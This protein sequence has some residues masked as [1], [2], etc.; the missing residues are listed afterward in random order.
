[1]GLTR[2]TAIGPA[3]NKKNSNLLGIWVQALKP[4]P[5]LFWGGPTR[6]SSS[7]GAI[8]SYNI[9]YTR[10]S[11]EKKENKFIAPATGTWY[12]MGH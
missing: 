11:Q 2:Q 9:L 8:I 12:I 3:N 4:G 5:K 1:M 7:F 10:V 6:K